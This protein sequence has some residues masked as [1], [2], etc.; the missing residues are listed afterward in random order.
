MTPGAGEKPVAGAFPRFGVSS[1]FIKSIKLIYI[2][3]LIIILPVS[4]SAAAT[5]TDLEDYGPS[6]R[7]AVAVDAVENDVTVHPELSAESMFSATAPP[8]FDADAY[9]LI[10]RRTGLT[11]CAKNAEARLYPASTTK[12]MT[13]ILALEMGD[14]DE[15]MT[16]SVRAVRDIG[17]DGSN[18]GIIAGEKMRLDNL[19]DALLVRSANETANIIA[20][21]LCDTRDD[22]I[23]LMNKKAAEL[24]AHNT[25][26]TNASGIHEPTHYT[27]AYDLARMA[28][29]AM[30]NT[31]F[32]E[33][34]A[35][36]SIILAPTNKH[37]AWDRMNTTNNLLSDSSLRGFSATGIKTGFHSEAG[38]C[39]V[40]SGKDDNNMEL[41]CVVLG[42]RG[43]AAGTSTRRFK[44]A[45]D[46]LAYG[47]AN[48]KTN[49]FIRDNELVG[50]VSVLGGEGLDTVDVVSNGT[51]RLLMPSEQT[52]WN[53]SRI[54]YI[55]SEIV[56]PVTNGDSIGYVEFR[57]AGEFAGKVNLTASFD[58]PA[59]KG[60][61]RDLPNRGDTGSARSALSLA[62]AVGNRARALNAHIDP[63]DDDA[64]EPGDEA[65]GG[66]FLDGINAVGIMKGFLF[67]L[68]IFAVLISIIRTIIRFIRSKRRNT[69]AR[70]HG[71]LEKPP[72]K[73][74]YANGRTGYTGDSNTYA[75]S[76]TGYANDRTGY[77]GGGNTYANG[78]TGYANSKN[79]YAGGRNGYANGRTRSNSVN[80]ASAERRALS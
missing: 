36:R 62:S 46:L 3:L 35:Q 52:H 26:F 67:V 54:E 38:Y 75:N 27:T 4:T 65:A 45:A 53:V 31:R 74:G 72:G 15:L 20:E 18:I 19:L 11:I 56:A 73:T 9:I 47:F 8:Y 80:Y 44:I 51:V 17:P 43:T 12:I 2:F 40:A 32:R 21:N 77:T 50:T 61:I 25:N 37:S 29:Y 1:K 60:G 79:G 58:I 55:K 7:Q 70:Y 69:N 71:K 39:I 59:L 5:L 42:V 64:A 49:T 28:N 57:N 30:D 78:R 66:S 68:L 63:E 22:F 6:F 16:A 76:K 41:L 48:F 24:G 34:V 23:G 10:E 13:A 14:M 33:I